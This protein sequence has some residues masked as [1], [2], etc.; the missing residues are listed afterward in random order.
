MFTIVTYVSFYICAIAIHPIP[1]GVG[2][3]HNFYFPSLSKKIILPEIGTFS[4]SI[5]LLLYILHL[6][7]SREASML[8]KT[9]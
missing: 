9:F 2:F 3:P 5:Y 8:S 7:F 1:K 4:D 6:N